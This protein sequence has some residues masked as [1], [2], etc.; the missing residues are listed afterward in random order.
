[1]GWLEF[2]IGCFAAYWIGYLLGTLSERRRK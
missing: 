1:M 2:A